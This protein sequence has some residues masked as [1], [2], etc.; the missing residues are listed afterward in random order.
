MLNATFNGMTSD[1]IY[2]PATA[3]IF[4]DV[5]AQSLETQLVMPVA[6][7]EKLRD[8]Q[9][10]EGVAPDSMMA[11]PRGTPAYGALFGAAFAEATPIT[12]ASYARTVPAAVPNGLAVG[13]N[14]N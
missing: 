7:L 5:R 12:A 10:T 13:G 3:A 9:Y 14:I 8:H 1:G 4:W 6:T 11:Q 2:Q